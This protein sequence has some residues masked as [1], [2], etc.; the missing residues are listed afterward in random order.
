MSTPVVLITG[1]SRGIGAA[2]ARA[3]V[4]LGARAVL[5]ARSA[6]A[7]TA[8]AR[9]LE[10]ADGEVLALPGDVADPDHADRLV[11]ATLERFGRLD[12][13]IHNAGVLDPIAPVAEAE[14]EAWRRNWSINLLGPVLL[15]RAALPA[16]RRARG[17]VI[18]VSSGA[19]HHPVPGWG[20][21]CTSKAALHMFGQVLA[22]EEPDLTVVALRPGV[23]DTAMQAAIRERGREGMPPEEHARFLRYHRE[24]TLLPP[25]VPGRILAWLALHAPRAWSGRSF[26][27]DDPELQ[28][29]R[30]G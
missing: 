25:E 1:A 16:L 6:E 24:G 15:T 29:A 20:A 17:R 18:L 22:A 9:E 11:E 5:T 26:A 28:E 7:L 23:V 12:G 3:L 19:A 10:G 13:L 30:E 8:L 21:Y 27:W 4:R 14:G 2:A